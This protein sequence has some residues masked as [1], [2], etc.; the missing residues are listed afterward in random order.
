M[1]VYLILRKKILLSGQPYKSESDQTPQLEEE[2][3][4]SM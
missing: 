1:K 2:V 4:M 3:K